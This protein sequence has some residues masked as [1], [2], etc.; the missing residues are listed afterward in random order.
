MPLCF[1]N[2]EFIASDSERQRCV[3]AQRR[4][5]Y[6]GLCAEQDFSARDLSHFFAVRAR[7]VGPRHAEVHLRAGGEGYARQHYEGTATATAAISRQPSP[8]P[9]SLWQ[10][11]SGSPTTRFQAQGTQRMPASFGSMMAGGA[12]GAYTAVGRRDGRYAT[13]QQ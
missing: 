11:S 12:T 7:G 8:E 2:M 6:V 9:S 3:D 5:L 10:A 4:G 1:L 13:M